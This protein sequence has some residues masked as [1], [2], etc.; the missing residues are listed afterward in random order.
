MTPSWLPKLHHLWPDC[1]RKSL[2][3]TLS[4]SPGQTYRHG[5]VMRVRAHCCLRALRKHAPAPHSSWAPQIPMI[6]G[7]LF[8]NI[9]Q[10]QCFADLSVLLCALTHRVESSF[11]SSKNN[12]AFL[13]E[14][15]R[16]REVRRMRPHKKHPCAFRAEPTHANPAQ[17]KLEKNL[18]PNA[19]KLQIL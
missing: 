6:L 1:K 11:N 8:V 9:L 14:Q 5:W 12:H 10:H 18:K 15:E 2:A 4:T 13:H 19:Q 17:R 16:E 7:S 3:T